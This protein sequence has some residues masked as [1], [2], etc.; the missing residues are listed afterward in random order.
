MPPA[1]PRISSR[2]W[3]AP[4]GRACSS[5][6]RRTRPIPGSPI[7]G[8][9]FTERFATRL[10]SAG[11][12][13]LLPHAQPAPPEIHLLRAP[14]GEAEV[15]G[16]AL[17]VRALLDARVASESIGVVA[18]TLTPY[19]LRIR[20]HF[21][22][23]G[24]PFSTLRARSGP[25]GG[26]RRIEAFLALLER[27]GETPAD[28]WID[29]LAPMSGGTPSLADLRMALHALG[30]ARIDQVAALDI[31][32]RLQGKPA[33]ALPVRHGITLEE[34]EDGELRARGER[35]HVP[36]EAL[37]VLVSRAAR[38]CEALLAW[39]DEAPLGEHLG[40]AQALVR[41]GARLDAGGAGLRAAARDAGAA[42]RRSSRRHADGRAGASPS[43]CAGPA[44]SS[45][46]ARSAVRAQGCRS[47]TPPRRGREPSTHLFVL[48]MNRDLFPRVVLEDPLFPDALRRGLLEHGT[49]VLPDLPLKLGG[50]D[51]ERYLFAQ[52]LTASPHVTLS[53]QSVDDDGKERAV[54]TFVERLWLAGRAPAAEGLPTL[55]SLGPGMGPRPAAEHLV[56]AGLHGSRAGLGRLLPLALAEVAAEISRGRKARC[57]CRRPRAHGGARS[58]RAA[59]HGAQ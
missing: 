35:R 13:A 41:A 37:C 14:G 8:C 4:A 10:E 32:R 58:S 52:L 16:V 39:P 1:L 47:S 57:R 49:G 18:R 34:D 6:G 15:R 50:F 22:K 45:A 21:G 25:D 46:P 23:L 17:R 5:T 54:S 26:G 3:C 44:T 28:R 42:R 30:A 43:Y 31:P 9:A 20:S 36:G 53:W 51:E 11:E 27:R 2:R 33:F 7:S 38:L 40:R 55:W 59:W 19:A 24:I 12:L 29:A 56:L 48:G